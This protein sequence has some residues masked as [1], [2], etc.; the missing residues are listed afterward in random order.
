M[1]FEGLFM[2]KWFAF[3][4]L[5]GCLVFPTPADAQGGIKLK[6]MN[7]LLWAE[8]D[9]PSMLVIHQF[10]VDESTPLPA[11]V[12]L[13]FPSEGNL[14]AVAYLEDSLINANY[15]GPESQ[16]NWQTVTLDVQS[17]APHRIEYYQPLERDGNQRSFSFRWFGDYAVEEFGV[18]VQLPA[19]STDITIDPPFTDSAISGDG[20]HF[21][22]LVTEQ[23]LKM[24][25]ANVFTVTYERTS[26]SVSVPTG[27]EDIR[28]SEPIGP[29]TEGRVSV[30]SLPWVIGGFGLALIGLALYFY[31][32]STQDNE[33][34][35]RRRSGAR[36]VSG[37]EQAYCHECGARAHAGDRFCRTCGSKL[38]I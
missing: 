7:I 21:V 27:S 25:Q 38:R 10:I 24:G 16:G 6:S 1:K 33:K 26:E 36:E 8:Y 20:L 30:D 23:N 22:G 37:G 18:T 13:R 12:T 32:R 29:S 5:M 11:R 31:W 28:P 15:T 17:Y 9:Q 14:T 34:K 3:V 35:S 2:R 4:L 19:D